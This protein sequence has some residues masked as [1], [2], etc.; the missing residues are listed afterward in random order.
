M[1]K[2]LRRRYFKLLGDGRYSSDKVYVRSTDKDR[3]LMSAVANLAGLFP[4]EKD[5]IWNNDIKN[6]LPIPI[7]TVPRELD[8]VVAAKRPCPRYKNALKEQ[9]KSAEFL[10]L[11]DS[12][13]EHKKTINKYAG[14]ENADYADMIFV[15]DNLK[16]QQSAN[17][18]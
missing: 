5:Q 17:L 13:K 3:T 2:Y 15:L 11:A 10:A 1:G 8:H 7:H 6:W 16:K 4:P 14:F 12:I 9:L 18:P